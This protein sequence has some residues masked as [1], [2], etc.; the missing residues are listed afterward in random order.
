MSTDRVPLLLEDDAAAEG[1]Q[2]LTFRLGAETYALALMSVKEIIEYGG[3]TAV[4]MMPRF[5][6]GV[7][8]LR[9]R[10]VPVMDLALRFGLVPAEITR[11]S[12]IVI[13]EVGP[14]EA[15]QDTGVIV[16]TV[17]QVV[18]IPADDVEPAPSFGTRIR[19]DFIAGMG[20]LDGQFV[21]LLD[22]ERVLSADEVVALTALP[23]PGA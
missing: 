19:P 5:V 11:R 4:P 3:V 13:V 23:A 17:S 16:D 15:R 10:V 7:I 8:N 20:K 22:V 6:K 2:Y 21:I 14:P 9:G 12:C 18:E 1:R